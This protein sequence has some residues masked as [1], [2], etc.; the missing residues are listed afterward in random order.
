MRLRLAVLVAVTSFLT[1]LLP[2]TGHASPAS[3][4]N[5][6]VTADA[7]GDW[8]FVQR[9]LFGVSLARFVADANAAIDPRFDWSTDY[10][11]A[12]IVGDTGL[13]FNFRNACRRHDFGYRNLKLLDQ[14][15]G[16]GR[17][18][19]AANRLRVDQRF[20]A[21]MRAHCAT[22]SLL[23]RASCRKWAETY[24]TAVRVFGGP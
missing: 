2:D 22:R 4:A 14:R 10:C 23:L 3:P 11:S 9:E 18:W 15:Y 17:Y 19:N 1:V 12:P 16:A 8:T 6:A 5:S 24:Y 13:S 20:L 7:A 21:D